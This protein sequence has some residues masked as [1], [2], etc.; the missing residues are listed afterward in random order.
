MKG[1]TNTYTLAVN[2]GDRFA[3]LLF[4]CTNAKALSSGATFSCSGTDT[5]PT[6]L[7][8][9]YIPG[10]NGGLDVT[11][12]IDDSGSSVSTF[13][14]ATGG[15]SGSTD[16]IIAG[17]Q[18]HQP[19]TSWT[20]GTGFTNLQVDT[21]SAQM[22]ISYAIATSKS[23][24]TWSPSWTPSGHANGLVAAFQASILPQQNLVFM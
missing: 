8:V 17:M 15:M 21:G 4:Y 3:T 7:N 19:Q 16:L 10:Y 20:E 14:L 5:T 9:L 24:V 11:N 22:T 12:S 2:I 6:V 23:S 1:G 18:L 13:S